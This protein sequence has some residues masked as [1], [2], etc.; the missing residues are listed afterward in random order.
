MDSFYF[1]FSRFKKLKSK[2]GFLSFNFYLSIF[3]ISFSLIAIILTDSFTKGYKIEIFSKLNSLNPDFKIRDYNKGY[4]SYSDYILIK[5]ELGLFQLQNPNYKTKFTYTPYIQ[6][7]AIVF[8][9]NQTASQLNYNQREGVYIVGVEKSFLSDNFLINKYFKNKNFI[10]SDNSIIIGKYLSQKINKKINDKIT[11]LVFE[12]SF[13]G[14]VAKEFI[15]Q[16]IYETNTENDEF[17]VYVPFEHLSQISDNISCEFCFYCTGFIGDFLNQNNESPIAFNND[18]SNHFSNYK[19]NQ[20]NLIVEYW[21]SDNTLKFLNSFD[22]PIKLLMWI[23]MFLSVYSLSS[24]IFNLL[25]EKKEDL[26]ILYLMGYGI[27]K[28]RIIVL[29][30]TLYISIISIFIGI[31]VSSFFM[32]IQNQFKIINLPSERIFQLTFLPAYFDIVYFIKYPI[33]L[34]LFTIIIS[35]YVFNK[36]FKVV[37]K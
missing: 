10:F 18:I 23:L 31:F 7:S 1:I 26:R 22:I 37:L 30:I 33:F 5:D 34:I 12:D 13:S 16:N 9:Q 29:S 17:L 6:K 8:A 21:D 32:Y 2:K 19:F 27:K 35:L 24:L 14:F 20:D 3:L 11:L 15:I 36:N 28:I 25:I 4:L